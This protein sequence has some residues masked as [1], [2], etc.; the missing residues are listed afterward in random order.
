[1]KDDWKKKWVANVNGKFVLDKEA[2][3]SVYDLGYTYGFNVYE[4][5]RTFNKKLW[6]L[7]EHTNRMWRS[8]KPLGIDLRM[9]QDEFDGICVEVV[10]RNKELLDRNEESGIYCSITPGEYGPHGRMLEFL[11]EGVE[12]EATFMIKNKPI[13]LKQL[14]GF[15]IR[16]RQGTHMV[17]PSIRHVPP[18]CWDPKI[19]TYNRLNYLL[20]DRE[21]KLV[22]PQARPLLMDIYG[23]LAETIHSNIWIFMDGALMTPSPRNSLMGISRANVIKLAKEMNIPLVE[24]DLQPWHLYNCDEAFESS[25]PFCVLPVSRYNGISVGKDVPGPITKRILKAW[26][27][28]IGLD[29]LKQW[30]Q[31]LNKLNKKI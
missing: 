31:A 12:P 2:V 27:E 18:Q 21:A 5:V 22:D 14:G 25:T 1:M 17:T 6:Q 24:R 23:N 8:L 11:P 26:S 7:R 4:Y 19:K 9:S 28:W 10:K 30:D 15:S 20:A 13:T 3:M 16:W 29:I